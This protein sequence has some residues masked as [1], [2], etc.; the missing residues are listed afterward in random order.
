[1]HTVVNC[2]IFL[3][4]RSPTILWV[5]TPSYLIFNINDDNLFKKNLEH[6]VSM[7]INSFRINR[8]DI[9]VSF[10]C[11]VCCKTSKALRPT[12]SLLRHLFNR[13]YTVSIW[14]QLAYY[15]N[16][17]SILKYIWFSKMIVQNG[18]SLQSKCEVWKW[19]HV[20]WDFSI[21]LLAYQFSMGHVTSP[22][23]GLSS[24]RGKS[25]GTRLPKTS[26]IIICLH[27]SKVHG[28]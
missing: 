15:K 7:S 12:Q 26:L 13:I 8:M 19:K 9:H 24:K 2:R 22:D 5:N 25:L 27:K 18:H 11:N 6:Y 14:Q 23:Q 28:A 3:Y 16:I 1:M 17:A 10:M 4:C 20:I 21:P